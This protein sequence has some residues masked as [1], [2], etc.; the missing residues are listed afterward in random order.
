MARFLEVTFKQVVSLFLVKTAWQVELEAL[1]YKER[2]LLPKPVG[3]G[4]SLEPRQDMNSSADHDYIH[5][6]CN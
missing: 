4:A 3:R 5:L 2:G 1:Q 6:F